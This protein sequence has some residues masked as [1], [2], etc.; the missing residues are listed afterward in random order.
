MK[1]KMPA[2][3]KIIFIL[4]I[5]NTLITLIYAGFLIFWT[6][7]I[8]KD[9]TNLLPGVTIEEINLKAKTM[10]TQ[11]VITVLLSAVGL[12]AFWKRKRYARVFLIVLFSLFIINNIVRTVSSFGGYVVVKQLINIL[13]IIIYSFVVYYLTSNTKLKSY[14]SQ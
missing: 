10:V 12:I 8:N 9:P 1:E 7:M 5:I 13:F 3:A 2:L 11:L 6:Y 4:L 14:L